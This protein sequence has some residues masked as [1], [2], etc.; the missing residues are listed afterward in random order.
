M[1]PKGSKNKAPYPT[2]RHRNFYWALINPRFARELQAFKGMH[3][4]V[5]EGKSPSILWSR[6]FDGFHRF[7]QHIGPIPGKMKKPSVG[8]K[9]HTQGYLP[10]NVHWEPHAVNS[11]KR[12]GTRYE[13]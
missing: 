7:L 2:H 6:D 9:E 8:R 3:N 13:C 4:R 5:R 10:G 11:I 1:K 12:R